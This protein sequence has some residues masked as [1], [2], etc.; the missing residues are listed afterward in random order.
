MFRA[1][2]QDLLPYLKEVDP[3]ARLGPEIPRSGDFLTSAFADV[4]SLW[5][6]QYGGGSHGRR[7]TELAAWCL[8]RGPRLSIWTSGAH[9]AVVCMPVVRVAM[10]VAGAGTPMCRHAADAEPCR[11]KLCRVDGRCW[12][13]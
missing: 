12:T 1:F 10:C 5:R 13:Q 2:A 6:G 7:V 11:Q 3:V 9:A 8:V 4:C